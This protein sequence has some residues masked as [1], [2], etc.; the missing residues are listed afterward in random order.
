M[1]SKERLLASLNHQQP[2]KVV[3]DQG[4]TG[5]T[6]IHVLAVENLRNYYGLEKKPVKV[7]EP[8][9]MLGEVDE[10][11]MELM[12]IDVVGLFP[13]KNMFG[14]ANENWKEFRTFWGQEVLVPGEFNTVLDTNGDLLIFPEGDTT[15]PP[16]GKMPKASY[17]FDTIIRQNPIIDE[18]LDPEDNLE[19][20]KPVTDETLKY[21]EAQALKVKNTNKGVIANFGGTAVGD[22]ALVPA[23]FLKNPK[24]IRDIA[25]WYMSLLMRPDY[26][27]HIFEKQTEIAIE[28][29]MK[30]SPI[31][32]K[33]VDAV[34]LCGTDFGTQESTFCSV[35]EFQELFFPY[36]KRINDWIH[37]NTSWK[38]FKHSCGAVETLIDSF[39]DCGFDILNPVQIN[40]TGMN[41]KLLKEKYGKYITIL[42]GMEFSAPSSHILVYGIKE[43]LRSLEGASEA[44][45]IEEVH[46]QGGIAIP[47]HPFRIGLGYSLADIKNLFAIEGLNGH[48]SPKENKLSVDMAVKLTVPFIGGSDA[49]EPDRVGFCYTEFLDDNINEDNIIEVLR[50]GRYRG[51]ISEHYKELWGLPGSHFLL[52]SL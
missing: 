28:N 5:V 43:D 34:F 2:D 30:I 49:H 48:N 38:I 24:G 46:R 44:V 26:I 22:I 15:A 51:R 23:P 12:N 47:A 41:P 1:T 21:W 10:E 9:Q 16:S 32:G 36:Y 35:G 13:Q 37:Q 40:A 52:S 33:Y 3:I 31:I 17:F 14:F 25:E 4:S 27:H 6:G 18:N 42:R 11:L 8:Y 39:I 29:L 50:S 19:E 45:F 7:T 20:F